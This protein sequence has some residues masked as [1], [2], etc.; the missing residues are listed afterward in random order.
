VIGFRKELMV[1]NA[2]L[3]GEVLALDHKAIDV[4]GLKLEPHAPST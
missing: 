2:I 1:R 3:D 4:Y